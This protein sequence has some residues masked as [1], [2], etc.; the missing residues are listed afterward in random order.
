MQ[1]G[2]MKGGRGSDDSWSLPLGTQPSL[3]SS[4]A[5]ALQLVIGLRSAVTHTLALGSL[6]ANHPPSFAPL[7]GFSLSLCF[8]PLLLLILNY[9]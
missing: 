7:S 9:F 1:R 2:E 5:A 6:K 3:A 4:F 8:F